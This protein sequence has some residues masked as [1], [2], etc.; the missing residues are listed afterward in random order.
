MGEQLFGLTI[1][2]LQNLEARL[3]TSLRDIR[4]KKKVS[5]QFNTIRDNMQLYHWNLKAQLMSFD[6]CRS[7]YYIMKFNKYLCKIAATFKHKREIGKR[8][9]N[10]YC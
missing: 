5:N 3:E 9:Y 2:D 1:K 8:I 7:K 6:W 10:K 4:V